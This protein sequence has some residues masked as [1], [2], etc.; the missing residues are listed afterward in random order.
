MVSEEAWPPLP[1]HA[2]KDTYA[3][4][5]MWMQVVGKVALARAAPLKH[6]WGIAF[7]ITPRGLRTSLLRH[8]SRSFTIEFDFL[9]HELVVQVSDGT[10]RTLPLTERSVASFYHEVMDL[11]DAME[12]PVTIWSMPVELP[13]PVRFELD[14]AHH[15]Y[16]RAYARR[17][18][19]VFTQVHH[20][21]EASRCR[22]VGKSSPSHFFWGSF[23]LAVT[24]FS[25]RLAPP[26]EGPAFERDAY[27]HEVISHG[28]WPGSGPLLEPA[29]YAYAAPEPEALSTAAI[30]PDGAYYHTQL[31]EFILPYEIVRASH[32]PEA[33]ITEFIDSTYDRAATL[34]GWDRAAL[35][36]SA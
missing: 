25:G 31:R 20:V 27:S 12:L 3:T 4:L 7:H 5:H 8:G 16:D 29:F 1:Y 24:R 32:S 17:C 28:F 22:F 21:F 34:A 11:L 6:G 9:E 10:R 36:R 18:W 23:E 15:H 19:R 14:T 13:A 2:W 35:D 33:A 26:R 30:R